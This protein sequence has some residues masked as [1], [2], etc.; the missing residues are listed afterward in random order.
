MFCAMSPDVV[1]VAKE[2]GTS[3]Q[4]PPEVAAEVPAPPTMCDQNWTNKI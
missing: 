2:M 4:L 3:L 1:F